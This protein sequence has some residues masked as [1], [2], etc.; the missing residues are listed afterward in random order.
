MARAIPTDQALLAK[1]Y[2]RNLA[3]F[4]AHTE[5][6][7][8]RQTKIWVPI[9][10]QA[11][12]KTFRCDPELIFGRLYYHFNGKFGSTSGDGDEVRFFHMRLGSD[13][14]VVNFPLLASVLADLQDDHKRFKVSTRLA[15][16]S[17]VVSSISIM[18][19]VFL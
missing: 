19:A 8:I 15:S 7:K 9:D 12:G 2:E 6:N 17:L 14:H 11:L 10:I 1:I 5:D 4:S 16:L 18:L 13:K 3:T